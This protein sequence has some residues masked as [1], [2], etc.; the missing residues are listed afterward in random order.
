M[1][2]GVRLSSETRRDATPQTRRLPE[3]PQTRRPGDPQTRRPG[4]PQTPPG[5]VSCPETPSLDSLRVYCSL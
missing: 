4:H 2:S 5:Q 3:T 1:R